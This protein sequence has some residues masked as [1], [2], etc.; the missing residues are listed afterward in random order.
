MHIE[1]VLGLTSHDKNTFSAIKQRGGNNSP[2]ALV[3]H[4]TKFY[5]YFCFPQNPEDSME[6]CDLS[7]CSDSDGDNEDHGIEETDNRIGKDYVSSASVKGNLSSSGKFQ[8]T[9]HFMAVSVLNTRGS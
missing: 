9:H 4:V 3:S 2:L 1:F 8:C 5:F 6:V 7:R